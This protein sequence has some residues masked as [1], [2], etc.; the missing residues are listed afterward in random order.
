MRN[1]LVD[2]PRLLTINDNRLAVVATHLRHEVLASAIEDTT[3]DHRL[4]LLRD[5]LLLVRLRCDLNFEL[6]VVV[7]VLDDEWALHTD[8]PLATDD[9]E[10][11]NCRELP[12][13]GGAIIELEM[14]DALLDDIDLE[15][16]AGDGE[17]AVSVALPFVV[18]AEN[19]EVADGRVVAGLL[20]VHSHAVWPA[21]DVGFTED[22][23]PWLLGGEVDV[24]AGDDA[25][26]EKLEAG[27]G[28]SAIDHLLGVVV[29]DEGEE[30]GCALKEGALLAVADGE[31]ETSEVHGEDRLGE[32]L[33][34][35]PGE[36]ALLLELGI[37]HWLDAIV[38]AAGLGT[39]AVAG[40]VIVGKSELSAREA[41]VGRVLD[42]AIFNTTHDGGSIGRWGLASREDRHC[43]VTT[44]LT[45]QKVADEGFEHRDELA[46]WTDY[47]RLQFM[48]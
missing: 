34:K 14:E 8:V 20:A 29:G 35:F 36:F 9:T 6:E 37:G 47:E 2:V 11:G 4:P 1:L 25:G 42:F 21:A 46:R 45:S 30:I 27:F 33:D 26:G 13:V 31:G 48:S 44:A 15:H 41:G 5:T 19:L 16:A 17:V 38:G 10:H 43:E 22:W 39:L 40:I 3:V 23:V 32:L 7:G 18:R 12:F 24:E 28:D